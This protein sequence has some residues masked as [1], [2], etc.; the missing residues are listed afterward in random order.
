MANPFSI[1]KQA[2]DLAA[3]VVRVSR[4]RR[5]PP[6]RVK[7]LG[8]VDIKEREARTIIIG[9]VSFAIAMFIVLI[10]AN[11]AAGWSPRQGTLNFHWS[12]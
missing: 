2:V 9:I 6:P 10:A 8:P 3:P 5:D 1:S 7:V 11:N 12:D 4:I